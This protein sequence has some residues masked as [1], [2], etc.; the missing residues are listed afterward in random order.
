MTTP[1][2]PRE[3]L[4]AAVAAREELGLGPDYDDA[5]LETVVDRIEEALQ[6]R[7]ADGAPRRAKAAKRL[8][9]QDSAD[10]NAG[11]A[12]AIVSL[13]AAIP[14]SAIGVAQADLPGLLIVWVGIVLVNVTFT[15]RPRRD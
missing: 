13:V 7:A 6:A 4:K 15:L 5:F 1:R 11:L 10:R 8:A 3:D 14:L 12:L 2:L 9:R